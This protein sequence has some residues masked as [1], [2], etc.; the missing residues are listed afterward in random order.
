MRVRSNR[1]DSIHAD[2]EE[3]CPTRIRRINSRKQREKRIRWGLQPCVV[4]GCA[5]AR[6]AAFRTPSDAARAVGFLDASVRVDLFRTISDGLPQG[7]P[8]V[9][10][11]AFWAVQ[12]ATGALLERLQT[13]SA[14]IHVD[15]HQQTRL[16]KECQ[17]STTR[18]SPLPSPPAY[19]AELCTHTAYGAFSTNARTL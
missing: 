18:Y 9:I 17:A 12:C 8:F 11:A 1:N 13:L 10:D 2:S 14:G 7:A 16:C 19:I 4:Q 6:A 15:R 3:W 5:S